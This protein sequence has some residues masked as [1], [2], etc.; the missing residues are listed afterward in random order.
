MIA[1]SWK[2]VVAVGLLD[3]IET[4]VEDPHK[5]WLVQVNKA[6]WLLS[7][8]F[9]IKEHLKEGGVNIKLVDLQVKEDS[10]GE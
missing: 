1:C 10:K 9:F 6:F 2:L 5:V 4:L 8:D 7:V 3:A